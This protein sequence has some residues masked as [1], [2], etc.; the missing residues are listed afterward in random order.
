MA[1]AS[2]TPADKPTAADRKALRK[3]KKLLGRFLPKTLHCSFCGKS[4]H[5]VKKLIAGPRVFI[6]DQCVGLCDKIIAGQEIPHQ[7]SFNPLERPT[8][9]LLELLPTANFAVESNRD[10]LQSLVED[11]RRREVSW[12]QIAEVLGVSRQSAWERFS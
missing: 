3:H 11:L 4:Q 7:G 5:K 8:E 9:E 12:A 1:E 2:E 6:C 10:F